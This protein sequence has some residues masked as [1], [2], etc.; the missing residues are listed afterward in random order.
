MP[1]LT[2]MYLG[3]KRLSSGIPPELGSYE[4]LQLLDLSGNAFSGA[5]PPKLSALPSLEISLNLIDAYQPHRHVP[6]WR[7]LSF[8]H[9][10]TTSLPLSLSRCRQPVNN[11]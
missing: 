7:P 5:I 8:L 3:K 11:I 1:E 6:P 4:K 9:A 2:K 10:A